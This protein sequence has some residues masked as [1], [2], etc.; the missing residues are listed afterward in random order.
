MAETGYLLL[1]LAFFI[2]SSA[3]AVDLDESILE[4]GRNGTDVVLLSVAYIEQAAIFPDSNQLLRRIA[5]VETHDGS[6]PEAFNE[7][8]SGGIWAVRQDAFT[9]TQIGNDS[10]LI[11]KREQIMVNFGINWEVVHWS[12]LNKPFYSALAARLVLLI[13]TQSIPTDT[14]LTAQAQFWR[15]NYKSDGSVADFINAA[16]GLGG[17]FSNSSVCILSDCCASVVIN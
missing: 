7:G 14:D 2:F 17:E 15:E 3:K 12:E 16:Q 5:Y 8:N 13:V 10:N 11:Q 9:R 6:D 4:S 1:S